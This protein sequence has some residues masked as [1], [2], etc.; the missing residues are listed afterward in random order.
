MNTLV[1]GGTGFI[2]R[3]LVSRLLKDGNKV[4][5]LTR[6]ER[7]VDKSIK[8]KAE[9]LEA[10]ICDSASL[11][12]LDLRLQGIDVLIH[13][14]ASLDY[15]GDKKKLFQVNAG[16]TIN[17]LH[18]AE[19][20]EVKRFIFISSIEAMGTIGEDDIPADETFVCQPV[21][22]Y[23]KSKLEAEKRV[24]RFAEEKS[25]STIVLRLGNVY[26]PGSPA[27][28]VPIANAILR[29]DA[30][31]KFLPVYKDRY[32]HFVYIDDVIDGIVKSA[33]R[34]DVSETYILSGEEYVTIE[35][36]FSL[37]AQELDV[38]IEIKRKSIRDILY[39]NLRKKIHQLHKR[40]DL[41]TYFMAGQGRNTHRAYSIE[42]A[43]R[44]LGYSPEVSL[45]DGI[46]KTIEWA[47][48]EGLL[49]TSKIRMRETE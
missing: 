14:A 18:L 31:V 26:G 42:K 6:N 8:G 34:S 13:L 11:G 9:V 1:T 37:I 23:G 29:K 12:R 24:R 38:D 4:M 10:D 40:A 7:R 28:I 41:L 17:V 48:Q 30:L 16:G 22:T 21:S 20:N 3:A 5:V 47:K 39:L 44:E 2:G 46:A 27:F 36:L 35:T 33:Q 15:F 49:K 25:L 43:K 32:L 45:R 19:R